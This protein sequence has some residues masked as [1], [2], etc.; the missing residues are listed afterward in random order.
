MSKCHFCK[1][2][3]AMPGYTT[4]SRVSHQ[5]GAMVFVVK[6]VPADVCDTCGEWY[7]SHET[8][9]R[10]DEMQTNAQNAGVEVLVR[11]YAPVKSH[12]SEENNMREAKA[13]DIVPQQPTAASVFASD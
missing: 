9:L 3:Y 6:Q 5:R 1:D 12:S 4:V 10:L 8:A 2:G 7:M 11:R 13:T